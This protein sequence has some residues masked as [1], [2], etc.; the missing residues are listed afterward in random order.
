MYDCWR[1]NL[2]G[3]LKRVERCLCIP[4]KMTDINGYDAVKLWWRYVND[5]DRKALDTLLEYNREDV[6]N[7]KILKQ[8]LAAG[9]LYQE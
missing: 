6:I 8:R 2:Y 3:G 5:C 7:L 9:V 1:Q 4:R